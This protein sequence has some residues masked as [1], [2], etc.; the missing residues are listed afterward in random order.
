MRRLLVELAVIGSIAAALHTATKLWADHILTS[1]PYE[2]SLLP[3]EK[4]VMAVKNVD[5]TVWNDNTSMILHT[6]DGGATWNE[7]DATTPA[8]LAGVCF[9][10]SQ[11]GWAISYDGSVIKTVTGGD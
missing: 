6:D 10:G 8:S 4:L 1:G 11:T 5:R 3:E 7:Q 9:A 2:C